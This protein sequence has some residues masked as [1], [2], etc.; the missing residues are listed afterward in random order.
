MSFK[1][2]N[3]IYTGKDPYE[4]YRH[5]PIHLSPNGKLALVNIKIDTTYLSGLS[6]NNAAIDSSYPLPYKFG[7]L[8]NKKYSK[9]NLNN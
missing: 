7:K 4:E 2:A 9:K 8:S 5:R 3:H 1:K 6:C